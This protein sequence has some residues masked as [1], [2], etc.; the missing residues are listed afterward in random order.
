MASLPVTLNDLVYIFTTII[1][2]AEAHA[3]I[4]VAFLNLDL[5]IL[6]YVWIVL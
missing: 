5:S 6:V 4:S 1:M 3:Q 2:S